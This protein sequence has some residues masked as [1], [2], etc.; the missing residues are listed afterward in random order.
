MPGTRVGKVKYFNMDKGFGFIAPDDADDYI[1][2]IFVH[3]NDVMDREALWEGLRVNYTATWDY[4][5][6]KYHATEVADYV[7]VPRSPPVPLRED[8]PHAGSNYRSSLRHGHA[9]GDV[10]NEGHV[11]VGTVTYFN[12]DKGFGFIAPNESDDVIG[13]V[14]VHI[15]DVMDRGALWEGQT[16]RYTVAWNYARAQY[17]ATKVAAYVG[18]PRPPPVPRGEL[19]LHAGSNYRSGPRHGHALRASRGE[20]AAGCSRQRPSSPPSRS[21]SRG[22]SRKRSAS[23]PLASALASARKQASSPSIAVLREHTEALAAQETELRLCRL[24]WEEEL[25]LRTQEMLEEKEDRQQGRTDRDRSAEE[26]DSDANSDRLIM[27]QA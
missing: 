13:E 17:H 10:K 27:S 11:R 9:P 23:I 24:F 18:L 4:K 26:G 3:I 25:V 14:F 15:K 21:R 20:R 16:V 8:I 12:T 2:D 5:R 1:G 19:I 22:R 7:A 6:N